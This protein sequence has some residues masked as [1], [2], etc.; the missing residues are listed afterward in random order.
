MLNHFRIPHDTIS[1]HP[2]YDHYEL[3]N[4]RNDGYLLGFPAVTIRW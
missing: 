3:S 4:T 2:I 1:H